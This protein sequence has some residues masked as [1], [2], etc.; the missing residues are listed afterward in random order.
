MAR[1]PILS[2][3]VCYHCRSLETSKAGIVRG[4]QRFYCRVCRRFSREN[5][6]IPEG[7][8][9]YRSSN[10][11]SAGHLILELQ[12][13][14]QELGRTPTTSIIMERS[15][16]NRAYPLGNYYAVFGS[17]LTAVKRARLKSRYK[18]EF[19]E[20]DRE[21]MLGELRVLRKKL[22]RPIFDEDVDAARRRK[23]LSPPYHFQ[24]AFGFINKDGANK[25]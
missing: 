6:E 21:R 17:F 23:E 5:P 4:K 25:M 24:L 16:Q 3:V 13:I 18:Q 7:K 8:K 10:L 15:K 22:K 12:A 14:A 2:G 11:P 19:D 1:P 20:S 9:K